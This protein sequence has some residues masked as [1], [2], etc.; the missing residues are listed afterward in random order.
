MILD[1]GYVRGLASGRSVPVDVLLSYRDETETIGSAVVSGYEN[2]RAFLISA[3]NAWINDLEAVEGEVFDS[4]IIV[5]DGSLNAKQT[6]RRI[7]I[8]LNLTATSQ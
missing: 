7:S 8:F 6:K 4:W 5:L 2:V 3:R 1:L